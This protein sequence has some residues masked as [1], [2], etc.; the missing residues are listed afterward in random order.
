MRTTALFQI[1]HPGKGFLIKFTQMEEQLSKQFQNFLKIRK[2][3]SM[4]PGNFAD[5][6][7]KTFGFESRISNQAQ[8]EILQR[9]IE[10]FCHDYRITYQTETLPHSLDDEDDMPAK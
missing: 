10:K 5:L 8:M 1:K 3:D 2:F 7:T 6:K 4:L 9:A